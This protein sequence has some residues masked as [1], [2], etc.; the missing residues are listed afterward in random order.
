MGIQSIWTASLG[1]ASSPSVK[2]H[3]LSR[4]QS[5]DPSRIHAEF[6]PRAF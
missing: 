2:P 1:D 3:F 4:R 5:I 6:R